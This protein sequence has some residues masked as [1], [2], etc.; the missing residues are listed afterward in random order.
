M[1]IETCFRA[2]DEVLFIL[3]KLR[4]T[5][6][7]H[8]Q[9]A[10]VFFF[11]RGI[12]PGVRRNSN[13]GERNSICR[14][15]SDRNWVVDSLADWIGTRKEFLRSKLIDHNGSRTTHH[16]FR[17]EISAAQNW[18]TKR[19]KV[20]RRNNCHL[21]DRFLAGRIRRR[22]RN[23]ERTVPFVVIEWFV[24]ANRR[25]AHTW[26][27]SYSLE[28]LIVKTNDLLRRIVARWRKSNAHGQ[29][30]TRIESKRHL[31]RTPET[32]QSQARCREQ[33]NRKSNLRNH[34]DSTGPLSLR[35]ATA[36]PALFV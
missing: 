20:V 15:Q 21:A 11:T 22:A 14:R 3:R 8:R 13:N 25:R 36:A 31:L 17:S 4:C 7:H 19:A 6:V 28:Q 2:D 5:E 12:V 16:I 10:R 9:V 29:N 35:P 26:E 30:S 27:P 24:V 18:H 33:Q 34:Q 23:V 1:R 32:F